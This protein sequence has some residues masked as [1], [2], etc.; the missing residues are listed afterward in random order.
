MCWG[1]NH[2]PASPSDRMTL[3]SG[4]QLVLLSLFGLRDFPVELAGLGCVFVTRLRSR[5]FLVSTFF[6]AAGFGFQQKSGLP[7]SP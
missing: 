7:P 4:A 5:N 2:A 1:L 3:I 6:W